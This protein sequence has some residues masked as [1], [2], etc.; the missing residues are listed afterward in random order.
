MEPQSTKNKRRR[1]K[2]LVNHFPLFLALNYMKV[3]TEEL[4]YHKSHG[5][6]GVGAAGEQSL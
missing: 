3:T 6:L 4:V 5:T 1:G 2:N